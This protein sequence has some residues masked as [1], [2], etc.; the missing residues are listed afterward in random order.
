M[1]LKIGII[2]D[3]H[4][5]I[6][7]C[8]VGKIWIDKPLQLI[9]NRKNNIQHDLSISNLELICANCFMIK[10]GLDLFI[11]KKKE[12][13]FNCDICNFPLV[14]FQN[15]RKKK[16]ICLSCEKQMSKISYEQQEDVYCNK[17]QEMYS[18]NPVLSDDIKNRNYKYHNKV[19]KYK[20]GN[21]NTYT[22][23]ISNANSKIKQN[24]S[25]KDYLPLIELNTSIPDLS[26][27]INENYEEYE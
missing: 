15:S 19:S 1:L 4:C 8:K 12:I 16:G 23:E 20:Q 11:K 13:I 26:S 2:K 9:L 25:T 14:A 17:L 27:I 6:P 21:V 10:N 3:Y 18:D 22:N 5:N 24:S 7:K